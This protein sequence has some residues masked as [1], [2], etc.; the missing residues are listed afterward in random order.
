VIR[1]PL[2]LQ[3]GARNTLCC[4]WGWSLTGVLAIGRCGPDS[5]QQLVCIL[6]HEMVHAFEV[7]YLCLKK[8][9]YDTLKG[10]GSHGPAWYNA[11]ATVQA[12]FV[13][14][15]RWPVDC[16]IAIGAMATMRDSCWQL[17]Q[18]QLR[19]WGM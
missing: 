14:L 10:Q 11:M 2:K 5:G 4:Y 1:I 6:L 16:G 9:C 17:R 12:E 13:Q 3:Y 8:C 7:L 18:D 15:V 19:C